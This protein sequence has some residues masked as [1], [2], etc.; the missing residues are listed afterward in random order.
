MPDSNYN[1]LD[2]SSASFYMER[3]NTFLRKVELCTMA[4]LTYFEVGCSDRTGP[5]GISPILTLYS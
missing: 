1:I 4:T 2:H 5:I 3:Q